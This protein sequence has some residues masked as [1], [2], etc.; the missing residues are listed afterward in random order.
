[1]S[2]AQGMGGFGSGGRG[3]PADAWAPPGIPPVVTPNQR[4]LAPAGAA[5]TPKK[6]SNR[7]RQIAIVLIIIFGLALIGGVGY[8]FAPA[9]IK[10]RV[11]HLLGT[12]APTANAP[13]VPPFATYTPGPTPTPLAN[14][15]VNVS[16]SLRYV[17]DYPSAWLLS[18]NNTTTSGQYDN[19][20]T[21]TQPSTDTRLTV[22]TAGAF[23][24]Y[25]P[26]QIIQGEINAATQQ[27]ATFNQINSA[28]RT[29]EIG[30]EVWQRQEYT[31]TVTVSATP[32]ATATA[33]PS[34]AHLHMAILA[35]HHLGRGYVIILASD[36]T[37]FAKADSTYFEP[38]LSTFRFS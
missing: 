38:T 9:S 7:Q 2:D 31:V 17:I 6:A 13:T 32:T 22:E 11:H 19:L 1:M 30:G 5:D 10:S 28:T 35:T 18:T 4:G 20:D 3:A 15:K 29:Q 23:A 34:T 37:A 25:T 21:Y 12:G 33:T 8:K 27:G 16:P 14:D 26:S 36:D 24:S